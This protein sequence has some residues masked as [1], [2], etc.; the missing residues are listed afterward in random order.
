MSRSSIGHSADT[1]KSPLGYTLV[2]PEPSV[3][4]M[5]STS[6]SKSTEY[7]KCARSAHTSRAAVSSAFS[8]ARATEMPGI[9][10]L[11]AR[12]LRCS[13][14]SGGHRAVCFV[15]VSYSVRSSA[16][17]PSPSVD[18]LR[19]N[20][21]RRSLR[22]S[23]AL[24]TNVLVFVST[25]CTSGQNTT[26]T[27]ASS[28]ARQRSTTE[29]AATAPPATSAC[30]RW[31]RAIAISIGDRSTAQTSVAVSGSSFLLRRNA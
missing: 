10:V 28:R 3:R 25:S 7:L 2:T 21:R 27:L 8:T 31:L 20:S 14:V 29:D 23:S 4:C 12:R 17:R 22:C 26:C 15:S 19:R 16:V 18:L 30:V 11:S 13:M 5:L 1:S 24:C 6:Q 9:G